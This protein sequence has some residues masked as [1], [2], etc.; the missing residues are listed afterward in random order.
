M[1]K[2][3]LLS[4]L[5]AASMVLHTTVFSV[6]ADEGVSAG[7]RVPGKAVSSSGMEQKTIHTP[8]GEVTGKAASAS[9]AEQKAGAKALQDRLSGKALDITLTYRVI[10][11]DLSADLPDHGEL[12]AGYVEKVFYGDGGSA[13][14]GNFGEDRL[15]E[16]ESTLYQI[17]KSAILEI[18]AGSRI[19]TEISI[20]LDELVTK[21]TWT[22]DEL[23]VSSIWEGIDE[24]TGEHGIS[25]EA[26]DAIFS[27]V[28][29]DSNK[30]FNY[31][32]VNCPYELYWYDKLAGVWID[33][34][35]VR[36]ASE[37]SL[38]FAPDSILQYK[39]TPAEAYQGE[40][41]YT[42]NPDKTGAATQAAEN[43]MT[44][45]EYFKE[46]DD[47]EKLY[48]YMAA[49]CGLTSYNQDVL[50]DPDLPYGDPYQMIYVF[51]GDSSTGVVCEGY[52][53]AFQYLCDLSSFQDE[54]IACYT[55][56][57][58]MMVDGSD[59]GPHMW[60]IVTM[61]D[62]ENYLVDVTNCDGTGD[63]YYDWLF[64]VGTPVRTEDGIF[65]FDVVGMQIIY[66]FE[67]VDMEMYGDILDLA[68]SDYI[69]KITPDLN[70]YPAPEAVYGQTLGEVVIENP[71][72]NTPGTWV[73]RAEPDTPAG[74][75]GQRTFAADFIPEDPE[76]YK[77]VENI[78]LTVTVSPKPVQ[79]PILSIPSETYSYTGQPI[80]PEVTVKDGDVVIPADEYTVTYS[81]NIDPGTASIEVEDKEG[82]NYI[83]TAKTI[84]FSIAKANLADAQVELEIPQ[85]GYFYDKTPKEPAVLVKV[86]DTVI[87]AD[88][89]VVSYAEN[90]NAGEATVTV[91]NSDD[92][93]LGAANLHFMIQKRPIDLTV[94][95]EDKVY[96]GTAEA[97][98][99]AAI[100][101]SQVIPG[102]EVR[103]AEVSGVFADMYPGKDKSVTI[104]AGIGGKD[105]ANY[106]ARIPAVTA[107]INSYD[108]A[109][110][111]QAIINA[112][113]AREGIQGIDKE[114]DAVAKG[115]R[116]VSIEELG[117]F[118]EA[119]RKAEDARMNLLTKA[120]DEEIASELNKATEE[121]KKM[122][123]TGEAVD[124][125]P[126]E[127]SPAESK[128]E[129]TSPA[130]SQP[131]ESRPEESSPAESQ[132]EESSPIESQP[133]ESRPE[134]SSPAESKP[135]ESSPAEGQP[136]ESRPEESSPAESEP[137]ESRPEENFPAE[138]RPKGSRS[139]AGWRSLNGSSSGPSLGSVSGD[140]KKG[141]VNSADG[142]VTGNINGSAGDG[143]SHW[144]QKN[145]QE[146]S[147]WKLQ[148]ADGTYASG[149]MLTDSAGNPYEQVTWEKINGSWYAFGADAN[150]KNGWVYD[151]ET[152]KWYY[153]DINTGMQYG[154]IMV[155]G[156][157][158]Y[159]APGTA[160]NA[161]RPFGAMYQNETTPD[162]YFVKEDG[163]WD[164]R[165]KKQENERISK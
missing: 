123:R 165:V 75:A 6:S 132:P 96:D 42:V 134:E 148:Y 111:N 101:E 124:D 4:I 64:L 63:E 109:E 141:H 129:E 19:S 164:G 88:W 98:I 80:R 84:P 55:T 1:H 90:I 16:P 99:T 33:G 15:E 70:Q 102:D 106:E 92:K 62:G 82:G 81:D 160:G 130:E 135:E 116:F 154:W 48:A 38:T 136:E 72:S 125:I 31:L 2:K 156:I 56:A 5:L 152:A 86:D 25:Q 78:E 107:S 39:M 44:I 87:D 105:A 12:F 22:A 47:Y 43:A 24:T 89:Y 13:F 133:E 93:C 10:P 131:E 112:Y 117:R 59:P 94:A 143:Y 14:Y 140:S 7:G 67:F 155:N 120:Q 11:E 66:A 149:N 97:K 51:D 110:I 122:I 126:E 36:Y 119:I 50:V 46:L 41:A 60:N 118:N 146:G 52:S 74:N 127:S 30:V 61:D 161:D 27:R 53:K 29:P 9:D 158:Y 58:A 103:L 45:V 17:M 26:V 113:A 65:A 162:G 138:R 163:S 100:D 153:V 157:W 115:V 150:A 85:D 137:E 21:M 77:L 104:K 32:M 49:I 139:G 142:I 108:P 57:G 34:L 95:A 79:D 91:S 147:A 159:L 73:W 68:E 37:S 20:P 76:T 18:A 144:Q 35:D 8:T 114:P 3:R 69:P 40:E 121:F 83:L 28:L 54:K 23:G 151:A 128:P 71:D 145:T